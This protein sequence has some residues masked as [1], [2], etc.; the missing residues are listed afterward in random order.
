MTSL[1]MF[2]GGTDIH[3]WI[4]ISI[5]DLI[6]LRDTRKDYKTSTADCMELK[7]ETKLL[8]YTFSIES[9]LVF[10]VNPMCLVLEK[11][12]SRNV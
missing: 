9:K 7:I 12:V 6:K 5:L 3:G 1:F 10:S 11:K 4:R 2:T 8:F